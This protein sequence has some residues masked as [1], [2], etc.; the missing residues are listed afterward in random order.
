MWVLSAYKHPTLVLLTNWCENHKE[1]YHALLP[2]NLNG[3][4]I[5]KE[6]GSNAW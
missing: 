4:F 1:N 3:E 5:F 2:P 6:G